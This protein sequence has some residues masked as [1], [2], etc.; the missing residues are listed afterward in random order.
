MDPISGSIQ[1][2]LESSFLHSASVPAS[3]LLQN[4]HFRLPL[5][6]FL[7]IFCFVKILLCITNNIKILI[8]EGIVISHHM[9]NLF[10]LTPLKFRILY[11]YLVVN[12]PLDSHFQAILSMWWVKLQELMR[13]IIWCHST[14]SMPPKLLLKC[15]ANP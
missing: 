2:K 8:L 9:T 1:K 6:P 15:I 10:L 11:I 14:S 13:N 7:C 5:H 4:W 12:C 3:F